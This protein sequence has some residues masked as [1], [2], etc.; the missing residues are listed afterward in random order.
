[1]TAQSRKQTPDTEDLQSGI[2]KR[3]IQVFLQVLIQA[4]VLFV[5][6][7]T[8][9]WWEGWAFIGIYLAAIAVNAFFML[10]LHPE[11]VAER[12]HGAAAGNTKDWD[13][14]VGLVAVLFYFIGIFLIAGL[15][16]R[17]TW[18]GQM[19][20]ALQVAG[21]V[22][23]ALGSGLFGWAMYTNIYFSSVVRIQDDRGHEVCDTGPYRFVRHPGYVGAALQSLATPLLLGSWWAL[24]PGALAVLSFAV[25]TA[26]EDRTLRDELAGYSD[27]ARQVRYRLLPGVW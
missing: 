21:F 9:R 12:G 26:L 24:I 18:T 8:L 6:A 17:F 5:A 16:E 13:K 22:V 19:P 4:V 10:R 15:D 7:G 1:M 2:S 20:L 14:I 11:T 23:W 27:Y 25:R 3:M